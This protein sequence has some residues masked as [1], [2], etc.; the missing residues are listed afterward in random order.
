MF[1]N[2]IYL[3]S[4]SSSPETILVHFPGPGFKIRPPEA[5]LKSTPVWELHS[6]IVPVSQLP[7]FPVAKW[8]A[9]SHAS[10]FSFPTSCQCPYIEHLLCARSLLNMWCNES[11][12]SDLCYPHDKPMKEMGRTPIDR[13][14]KQNHRWNILNH[15]LRACGDGSISKRLSEQPWKPEFT[16]QYPSDIEKCTL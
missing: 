7:S 9:S 14:S 8:A 10:I 4:L 16:T 15:M 11:M 12:H 1:T 3:L 13:R 2:P 6:K 5:D